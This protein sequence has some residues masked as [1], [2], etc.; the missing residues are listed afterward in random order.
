MTETSKIK[1]AQEVLATAQE[2]VK[3]IETAQ[4][5]TQDEISHANWQIN[6][7][8]GQLPALAAQMALD[9]IEQAAVDEHLAKIEMLKRQATIY[10]A[11]TEGL[12]PRY[13]QVREAMKQA[14]KSLQDLLAW[15]RFEELKAQL[16]KK[17]D[18]KLLAE[19]RRVAG[20]IDHHGPARHAYGHLAR[21]LK[22]RNP[23]LNI[24]R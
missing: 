3:R 23:R 7:L 21:E 19:A 24:R 13:T 20:N 4:Q 10:T 18:E 1:Q 5:Q 9:E 12:K 11:A 8:E 15:Q 22:K 2:E 14:E 17:Y 16:L 6:Q